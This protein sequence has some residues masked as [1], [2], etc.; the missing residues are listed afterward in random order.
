MLEYIKALI[1]KN[2]DAQ[3]HIAVFILVALVFSL[4][5]IFFGVASI[6][7]AKDVFVYFSFS[8][9][10]LAGIAGITGYNIAKNTK[11]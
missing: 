2:N 6:F 7:I 3:S 11:P 1:D 10:V 4:L 5:T 8:G 9:G